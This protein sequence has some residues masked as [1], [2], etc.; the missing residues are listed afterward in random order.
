MRNINI[1]AVLFCS[2]IVLH[3]CDEDTTDKAVSIDRY[4]LVNRHNPMFTQPDPLSPLSVGNGEFAF[5]VDITGLQTFPEF[6]HEDIPLQTQSHWGWHSFPNPNGFKL[7]DT[8]E[9]YETYGRK[10]AYPTRLSEKASPWAETDST[11]S[12]QPF[13]MSKEQGTAA[14][15]LRSNPH[16]IDLGRIGLILTKGDGTTAGIEDLDNTIQSLDLWTGRITSRF[17]FDGV[18]VAVETC[19]HPVRDVVAVRIASALVSK[20]RLGVSVRFPYATGSYGKLA[21]DWDNPD[22]HLTDIV[23]QSAGGISLKRTLDDDSYHVD[24]AW[25]SDSKLNRTGKHDFELHGD[26]DNELL[27]FVCGFSSE[28]INDEL[29]VVTETLNASRVHWE[30]FWTEGGAVDLSGSTDL[31]A[32][33]LERR[34]VLSQYLTAI[35]CAGSL[36]PQETGLTFNSWHGKFH[37]EMHWSHCVHFALWGRLTLMERSL[38]WYKSI[39]PMA[40]SIAREQGYDGARWPKMVGPEGRQSPSFISPLIMWQQPHPIYFAELIYRECQDRS[41]LETY[42]EVVEETAAF[43]ASYAHWSENDGRYRFGPPLIPHQESLGAKVTN[44]MFEVAYWR[45]GFETAQLWRERLGLSRDQKIDHI[46]THWP[47]FPMMDGKYVAAESVTDTFSNSELRN[48]HPSFLM[49]YGMVPGKDIDTVIMRQTLLETMKSWNWDTTWG[50][51][52]PFVAMTA[53]RLGEPELAIDILLKG[54]PWKNRFLPNGH[55]FQNRDVLP[56]FLPSNGGLLAV[57]A[58]M[59]AGWDGAPDTHAPGFPSDGTWTVK[60]EGLRRMP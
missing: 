58:M 34:I 40:K 14:H 47:G 35:Q 26:S 22:K 46:L 4:A 28:P 24:M 54:E 32:L 38:P 18:P 13:S 8:N 23:R 19:S 36:P 3:S 37:L 29:P 44:P 16:M 2:V 1:L 52:P 49:A 48:D 17:E 31:R 41:T 15:W 21:D 39:L 10:V 43:M 33:E 25:S 12:F 7:E 42:Y 6:H 57:A 59:A 53:V 45:Y 20:Q 60:W 9:L 56:V 27:E 55:C 11:E 30:A 5:T 50:S 51:E